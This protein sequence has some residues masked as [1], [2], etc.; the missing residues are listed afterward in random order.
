MIKILYL[1]DPHV[2]PSNIDESDSLLNF[3]NNTALANKADAIVILG[4]LLHTFGV[5]RVEVLNF[6]KKWLETLS[7]SQKVYVLTGNHDR[8]NQSNDSDTESALEVFNLINSP[9]LFIIKSPVSFGPFGFVPYIHDNEKFIESANALDSK[10][11]IAHVEMDGAQFENGFYAPHGAKQESLNADLIIS[12][13]IHRR[14]RFGKVIYPGTARWLT[15]SDANEEK[16]IWLVEHEANTGAILKEEFIDTSS[17]CTPIYKIQ[18]K[19][20]D[21]EPVIIEHSRTAIEL[22]GSSDWVSKQRAKFKNKCSIS[23]K[24][25]DKSK[26]QNRKSGNSLADFLNKIYEPTKGISKDK[27]KELMKELD[28]L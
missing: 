1:G 22:I 11:I 13:H 19:E 16:G 4:D 27:I 20:G 18:Y 7:L 12:G 3:V 17:V 8:K 2:M 25:T 28:I 23:C 26:T 9:N 6:W 5:V 10:V 24:I 21:D 14:S 15:S